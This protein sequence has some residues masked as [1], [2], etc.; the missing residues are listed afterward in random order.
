[1]YLFVLNRVST[2]PGIVVE[3]PPEQVERI[4]TE[5]VVENPSGVWVWA[6]YPV[7]PIILNK[8]PI[9]ITQLQVPISCWS[10]LLH[11]IS[12]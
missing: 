7:I 2:H 6:E 9:A 4:C 10:A 8:P 12:R 11:P 3:N 1:L 5:I